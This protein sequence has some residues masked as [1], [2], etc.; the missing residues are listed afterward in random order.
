MLTI[1]VCVKNLSQVRKNLLNLK[2]VKEE[3]SGLPSIKIFSKEYTINCLK[4]IPV[5]DFILKTNPWRIEN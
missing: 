2:M 3:E 1:L 4:E 5:I